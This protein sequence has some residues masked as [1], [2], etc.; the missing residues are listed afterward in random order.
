MSNVRAT[1]KLWVISGVL[2]AVACSGHMLDVGDWNGSAG[3]AEV[4]QA[5]GFTASS[6]GGKPSGSAFALAGGGSGGIGSATTASGG[7]GVSVS[8]SA[9]V[10]GHIEPSVGGSAAEAGAAGAGD[11]PTLNC[12]NCTLI[13]KT[14]VR[15][16]AS[17][18]QKVFWIEYGTVNPNDFSHLGDGRLLARDLDG[19]EPIVL[20]TS[21]AGP[22]W[23]ALSDAYVYV[24]IDRRGLDNYRGGILRIPIGGGA[25]ELVQEL[26]NGNP[27]LQPFATTPDYEYW[28]FSGTV[29]RIAQSGGATVET[30][31]THS[32][33]SMYVDNTRLYFNDLSNTWA[34]PLAGGAEIP[35]SAVHVNVMQLEG[36]YLY[37][38]ETPEHG[39]SGGVYLSRMPKAG[40]DWTHLA[41]GQTDWAQLSFAGDYYFMDQ[42]GNGDRQILR[43][44][45]SDSTAPRVV[46]ASEPVELHSGRMPQMPETRWNCWQLS[47]V[48]IF[49]S[50][51]H[52]LYLMPAV[53]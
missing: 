22:E 47:R 12:P 23:L 30:F 34:V 48:G 19:G 31:S 40:G 36:D 26:P 6:E 11:Q 29:Y 2:G 37:G 14:D 20:A 15:G 41:S 39:Q 7:M 45:V 1:W 16:V 18:A 51:Y 32:A 8:S 44:L 17:N 5:A 49:L 28:V 38:I 52:G 53:P 46:L 33:R 42:P 27:I 3:H 4:A 10:S 35:L 50:D 25:A 43:G 21:L 9:G 13:T 24:F